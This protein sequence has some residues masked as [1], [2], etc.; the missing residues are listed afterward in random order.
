[1]NQYFSKPPATAITTDLLRAIRE[2]FAINWNGI[3]GISHWARV[4][5]IGMKLAG[6][7]GANLKVVQLFAVFHD[8]GRHNEGSDPQHGQRGAELAARLRAPHLQSLSDDEFELLSTA[9]RL[10][11]P[12]LTHEDITV[13]TCFD[14]DRLDL[15]RVGTIPDPQYLCTDA[16]KSADMISWALAHSEARGI[17]NNVVGK[18]QH[19]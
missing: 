5:D 8:S 7:T 3:H 14:S 10:H 11:T 12:A 1:M 17:P 16:A 6:L 9:C 13:Q 18:F 19:M 4:Y 15:G 2:Q